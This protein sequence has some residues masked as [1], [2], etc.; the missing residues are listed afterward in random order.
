MMSSQGYVWAAYDERKYCS[1]CAKWV[2]PEVG[3]IK[4]KDC[5]M[6]LRGRSRGTKSSRFRNKNYVYY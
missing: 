3:Q 4:C 2:F 1:V 5:H 6:P